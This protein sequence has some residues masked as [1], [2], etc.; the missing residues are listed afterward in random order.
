[1]DNQWIKMISNSFLKQIQRLLLVSFIATYVSGCDGEEVPEGI[2]SEEDMIPIMLDIYLAEG[3]VNEL[4]VKRDSALAIFDV[5]EI[6]IL[7]KYELT[8]SVYTNSL[9]YY[10]DNPLKLE[11]IYETV[12]DSLNLMEK[13]LDEIKEGEVEKEKGQDSVSIQPKKVVD[14]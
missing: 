13:R 9:R 10:Y 1:M 3:K 4:R 8:D 2:L 5:Y 7:E 6:K 12:L 14:I 11:S